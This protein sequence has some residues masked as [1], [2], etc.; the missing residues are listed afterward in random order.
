MEITSKLRTW[1]VIIIILVEVSDSGLREEHSMKR[2]VC[3]KTQTQV[4]PGAFPTVSTVEDGGWLEH[5]E[6]QGV[7]LERQTEPG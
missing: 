1:W 4:V 5:I 2:T 3:L 6:L 7:N